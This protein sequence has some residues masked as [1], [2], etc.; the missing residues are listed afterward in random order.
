MNQSLSSHPD[1]TPR[2][3]LLPMGQGGDDL[4]RSLRPL[5]SPLHTGHD[6]YMHT[7]IRSATACPYSVVPMGY[8]VCSS[9]LVLHDRSSGGAGGAGG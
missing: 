4:S 3:Y 6:M 2:G 9:T 5:P 7:C 8:M 1:A